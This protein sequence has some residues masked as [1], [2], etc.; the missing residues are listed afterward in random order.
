LLLPRFAC[1]VRGGVRAPEKGTS[2]VTLSALVLLLPTCGARAER[3][4]RA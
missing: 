1:C 2:I 3:R 4:K